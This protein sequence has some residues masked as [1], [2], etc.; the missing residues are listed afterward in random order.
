MPHV[1]IKPEPDGSCNRVHV[2]DGLP[3]AALPAKPRGNTQAVLLPAPVTGLS[4][5]VYLGIVHTEV[6]RK[7]ENYFYQMEV[8]QDGTYF[9][10]WSA[11]SRARLYWGE[12]RV[13]CV[14]RG[15]RDC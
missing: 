4:R 14:N 9:E 12:G 1:V 3:F 7:Y 6:E 11:R 5:A 13:T 15:R 2:T 8:R 10:E